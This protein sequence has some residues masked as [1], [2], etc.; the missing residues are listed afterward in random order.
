MIIKNLGF[1]IARLAGPLSAVFLLCLL[2]QLGQGAEHVQG[3]Y[4]VESAVNSQSRRDRLRA[5]SAALKTV[6]VRISGNQSVLDRTAVHKAARKAERYLKQFSYVEREGEQPG[7][8]QLMIKLEFDPA[9]VEL[10]LRE[11]G[12]PMWSQNRPS[13]LVWLVMDDAQGR[14]FV[15]PSDVE[16]YESI[17]LEATRRGLSVKLPSLDL[18]DTIAISPQELW[19]LNLWSAERAAARYQVESLLIGRMTQLST[20]EWIGNWVFSNNGDRSKLEGQSPQLSKY[21]G[22]A[23]DVVADQLAAQYAIEPVKM[24]AGGIVMRLTGINTFTDYA[25]AINYLQQ[26]AAVRHANTIQVEKQ[27]ILVRLV[28]DGQ[29]HQLEQSLVLGKTLEK[30]LPLALA[31]AEQYPAIQLHYRWP[32][33][34]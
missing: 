19:Q 8:K 21:V 14:R 6:F 30:I 2:A 29:L 25:R 9:L 20:G 3:L 17:Q 28:A 22:E 33:L 13:T 10:L 18:E 32:Q 15:S 4:D 7:A 1:T 16:V 11:Q 34:H 31:E 23:M 26:L 5:T 27:Q 12:L 24:S